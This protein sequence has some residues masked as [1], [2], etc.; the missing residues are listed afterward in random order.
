MYVIVLL[1][2]VFCGYCQLRSSTYLWSNFEIKVMEKRQHKL[3]IAATG[4]VA[5]LKIPIL[6]KSVLELVSN[7]NEIFEV[8][9]IKTFTLFCE[10]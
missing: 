4:S 9:A 6:V 5:A 2:I 1:V 8:S 7:Q 3:L 10:I